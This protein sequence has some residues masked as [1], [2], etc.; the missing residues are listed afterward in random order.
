MHVLTRD[1]AAVKAE[2]MAKVPS[3]LKDG[4]YITAMDGGVREYVPFAN[5]EYYRRL[6]NQAVGA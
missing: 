1:K 4:G 2:I 5:Y 3:L 6:L